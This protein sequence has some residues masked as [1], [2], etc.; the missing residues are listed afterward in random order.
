M[1]DIALRIFRAYKI[2]MRGDDTS[3]KLVMLCDLRKFL[4]S[5]TLRYFNCYLSRAS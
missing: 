2:K 5:K 4:K 1:E 3:K